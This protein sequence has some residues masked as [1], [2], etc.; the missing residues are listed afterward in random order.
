MRA[1]RRSTRVASSKNIFSS[2]HYV[3]YNLL[4]GQLIHVVQSGVFVFAGCLCQIE[5]K[6]ESDDK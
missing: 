6:I 5:N 4:A 3:S 2:V 1:A